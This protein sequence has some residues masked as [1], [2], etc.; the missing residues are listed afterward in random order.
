MEEMAIVAAAKS[1]NPDLPDYNGTQL[2][3]EYWYETLS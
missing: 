3:G 1:D 2:T